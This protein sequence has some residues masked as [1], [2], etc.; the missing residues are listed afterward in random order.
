MASLFSRASKAFRSLLDG[1]DE[2]PKKDG[3]KLGPARPE[4]Y[5]GPSNPTSTPQGPASARSQGLPR[6]PK[7]TYGTPNPLNVPTPKGAAVLPGARAE[8]SRDQIDRL[9]REQVKAELGPKATPKQLT[10]AYLKRLLERQKAG[11]QT[12]LREA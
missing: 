11:K 12:N 5:K 4:L 10:D 9:I 1:D 7:R 2:K 3:K 6:E 8:S